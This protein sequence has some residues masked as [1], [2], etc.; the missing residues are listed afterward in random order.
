MPLLFVESPKFKPTKESFSK[1]LGNVSG[2]IKQILVVAVLFGLVL[3]SPLILIKTSYD[4]LGNLGVLV[5]VGFNIVY[6]LSSKNL[7][8]LSDRWGRSP[9]L[10]MSFVSAA[11]AFL[12]AFIGGWALLPGFLLFGIALGAFNSTFG[13]LVSDMSGKDKATSLGLARTVVGIS[14]FIGS[15]A[16]GILL[17]TVGAN[18]YL[19][20]TG[21]SVAAMTAYN[22][23]IGPG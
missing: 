6:A 13:P 19:I 2:K 5:Y 21:L 11:L 14:V 20:G 22:V 23:L 7:G 16:F 1:T 15:T 18:T 3:I 4:Q 12:L 8:A 17:D 10:N 9:V